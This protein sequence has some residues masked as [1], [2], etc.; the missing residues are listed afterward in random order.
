MHASPDCVDLWPFD[1]EILN[2]CYFAHEHVLP[3]AKLLHVATQGSTV[4]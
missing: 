4:L 2:P 1:F 3:Q